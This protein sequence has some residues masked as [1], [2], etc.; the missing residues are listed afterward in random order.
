MN[1][2]SRAAYVN[3][4]AACAV[5]EMQAMLAAN[6]ARAMQSFSPAFGE[7][8]FRALINQYGIHHNAVI[9]YLRDSP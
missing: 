5:I 4:M 6:Q 8:D 1:E 3:A 7:E 9:S 2:V